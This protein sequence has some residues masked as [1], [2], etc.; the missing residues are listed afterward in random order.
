MS[1]LRVQMFL[2]HNKWNCCDLNTNQPHWKL[3]SLHKID[4]KKCNLHYAVQTSSILTFS[5]PCCKLDVA[6]LKTRWDLCQYLL[7]SFH[8]PLWP[9]TIQPQTQT[10]THL[11]IMKNKVRKPQQR[12]L[13][14]KPPALSVQ[15]LLLSKENINTRRLPSRFTEGNICSDHV[16]SSEGLINFLRTAVSPYCFSEDVVES[17][18][19]SIYLQTRLSNIKE[20]ENTQGSQKEIP[21]RW[22][23]E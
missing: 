6:Y 13:K 21:T 2:Q 17:G 18:Q 15:A 9:G 1:R 22:T 10:I 20:Y 23:R 3:A 8:E 7:L 14:S 4:F 5:M 12:H 19:G 16:W 11:Q